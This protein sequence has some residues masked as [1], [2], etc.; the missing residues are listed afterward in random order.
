MRPR[1]VSSWSGDSAPKR[2][3]SIT[4]DWRVTTGRILPGLTGTT[5]SVILSIGSVDHKPARPHKRLLSRD[6][7]SG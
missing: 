2:H 3:E 5:I 4:H 6:C 7:A 1:Q